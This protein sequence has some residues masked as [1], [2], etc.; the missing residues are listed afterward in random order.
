M[1]RGQLRIY[2]GA[3]P[4]VGKT[5]AMLD[6]AH[7]RAER[8]T[9]VVVGLVET[10]GRA[11]TSA[12]LEGLEV[13]PRR[14]VEYRGAQLAE[15]D[16][17]AVLARRPQVVLVDELAHTNVP[18]S[19]HEKRWQDVDD[20]LD[21]GIDVLTT[22]N[23]QHLES[24]NDVVEAITGVRQGETVPDEVVRRADQ[25]ELVDMT[26]EALRRRMAHG[27]VYGPDKVDA[28]LA[29]YFRVGNLAALREIALLWL[30]D[31]VDE[32]LERYRADH[33]IHEPWPAR[34]RVVVALTGGPESETLLRRAARIATRAAG[35]DL[36]ACHVRPAE[37][38]ASADPT[39]L[40]RLHRLAEDLGADFHD[41]T[42]SDVANAI[43]DHARGVNAT[44]IVVGVSRRSRWQ[45]LLRPS[46]ASEVADGS[47][48][49]D[50]HLVSHEDGHAGRRAAR[51][52][53][54]RRLGAL[55][56]RRRIAGW[57]LATVGLG[58]LTAVLVATR[59]R[60]SL[61]LDLLLYLALT[62]ACALVGGI[63][64]A[65]FC[66]VAGS[67]VVNWFFTEP[68]GT[69]TISDPP[70]ALALAV[71]VL[72]AMAVSS[73]VHV[74]ARR[75][76][77]AVAAQRESA[78][79]AALSSDLLAEP[80]P[81]PAL[82]EKARS[83]LSMKTAIIAGPREGPDHLVVLASTDPALRPGAPVP[84]G[85]TW[86]IDEPVDEGAHLLL[87]G[88]PVAAQDQRLVSAYAA[89]ATIVLGR[90]RLAAAAREAA[91]LAR[92]NAARTTLL[93]AVSHDLRTPLASIKAG[94]SILRQPGVVL[95]PEDEAELLESIEDSS[96]RLDSLIGNL[97]DL[98]RLETGTVRAHAHDIDVL[99]ALVSTVRTTS[100]PGRVEIAT[101]AGVPLVRADLGLLD[102]VL[103]N[104]IENALRHGGDSEVRITAGR[105]GATVQIRVIDRG[106]GVAEG[107]RER[108]FA[109]FQR[110]G[111][112]PQGEGIGLGLA[113]A[114]G[115][116]AVMDGSL[117]AEDTPGGGLTMVI[118]LPVAGSPETGSHET[119]SHE[120]TSTDNE[121]EPVR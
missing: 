44:Q 33:G 66:A 28:A 51:R 103:A 19:G 34:E 47:G 42:G 104:V 38:L 87:A 6:E 46:I 37:G 9:D 14:A 61:S 118:E 74:A 110:V 90:E 22:V 50:V 96:D 77:Q 31:R 78:A 95:P 1:R 59:E 45:S 92:D 72:V 55:S 35:G 70:N 57:L 99:D 24:L 11:H 76:E 63:W 98:S 60:H 30:A 88:P 120:R 108:I 21:A 10:H 111:D 80:Q 75:T 49:I 3:A 91:G 17:E 27:N 83:A 67:V 5:V 40:T 69:F 53:G 107:D 114:R 115:L 82:L 2:L 84:D 64:P 25:V 79:L 18:G 71:F 105:I 119:K 102:R 97:L 15:L 58:V 93:A 7:R 109:A 89:H 8:G 85:V 43:L 39:S 68:V 100:E 29:N 116:M 48:D 117:T 20:L 41:V 65:L 54:G 4:G 36:I 32:A 86:S 81:L 73:L 113:V 101:G 62:V 13:L 12:M 121:Q 56:G 94:V 26:P 106:P 16:T 112:T 23:I 52:G